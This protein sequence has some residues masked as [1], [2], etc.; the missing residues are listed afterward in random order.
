MLLLILYSYDII[1]VIEN[2]NSSM[3]HRTCASKNIRYMYLLLVYKLSALY[4]LVILL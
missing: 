1:C 4:F 2:E 3:L